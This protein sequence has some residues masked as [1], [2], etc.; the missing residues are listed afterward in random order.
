[1]IDSLTLNKL[2]KSNRFYQRKI[3]NLER[4]KELYHDKTP[5]LGAYP[6]K[7]T[8]QTTEKCNLRCI[9]CRYKRPINGLMEMPYE[10]YKKVASEVLPYLIEIHPTNIGEPLCTSWFP[11]LCQDLKEFGV[12]LDLTTN[13]T[14]LDRKILLTLLPILSDIKISIDGA[15]KDTFENIRRGAKFKRVLANIEQAV[16]LREELELSNEPTIT[17]QMTLMRSNF[18]QLPKMVE[19]AQ[20]LGIDRVKAY[21]IFSFEA[22]MDREVIIDEEYNEIRKKTI[23]CGKQNRIDLEIAESASGSSLEVLIGRACPLLWA[24]SFIDVNGDVYP[25]HSHGGD[26]AGTIISNRFLDI[27]NSGF[28]TNLRN[29]VKNGNPAWHCSGCGMNY[30]RKDENQAVPYDVQNFKSNRSYESKGIR[31][32]SRM[33]QFDI[34]RT[35]RKK[36]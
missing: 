18:Q 6:V 3:K 16:E 35:G 7:L 36:N 27:W 5:I 8:I 22:S 29:C 10:L 20:S 21:H 12:L 14:L 31:W 28:Y 13:G 23:A 26:R 24:E 11:R 25:C 2:D 1:L 9:M 19:L 34:A 33:K 30:E 32:S 4:L 17:I 15:D